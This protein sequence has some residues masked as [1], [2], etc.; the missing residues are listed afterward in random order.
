MAN[1]PQRCTALALRAERVGLVHV[2]DEIDRGLVRVAQFQPQEGAPA[3]ADQMRLFMDAVSQLSALVS[4]H[5]QRLM[6]MDQRLNQLQE[7]LGAGN[8]AQGQN[9][10]ENGALDITAPPGTNVNL[11]AN[12]PNETN[13]EINL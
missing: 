10:I 7:A 3:T 9:A 1:F 13:A 12:S 5:D 8:G 2:A 4:K 11:T 6:Q